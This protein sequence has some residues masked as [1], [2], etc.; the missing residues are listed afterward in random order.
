VNTLNRS[1]QIADFTGRTLEGVAYRYEYPSRVTD[2][3]WRTHYFEE[4]LRNCDRRTIGHRR[5]SFPL[6]KLHKSDGGIEIGQTT[7]AHSAD[8]RA[9]M[10]TA[11]VDHGRDGDQLLEQI[12]E[13]GDVSVTFDAIRNSQR[14]TPHHGQIMQRA[15]IRLVDL[16]LNP[17]G[18]GLAKGA[19][20][21]LVR[22]SITPAT[23]A[24]ELAQRRL[25]LLNL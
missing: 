20:V 16:S 22:S 9:L 18:T 15:E 5:A 8:E 11:T 25:Q 13:W 14:R 7:F 4:M 19:E 6:T 2:D 3:G 12:E 10:F 17:A 21:Q 1:T 24:V 23:P